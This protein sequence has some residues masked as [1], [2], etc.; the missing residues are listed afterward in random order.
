MVLHFC[1]FSLVQWS[2]AGQSGAASYEVFSSDMQL[3]EFIIMIILESTKCNRKL[4]G[5]VV[6]WSKAPQIIQF[7]YQDCSSEPIKVQDQLRLTLQPAHCNQ[8]TSAKNLLTL[9]W[10]LLIISLK[11]PILKL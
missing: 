9:V 6:D 7:T 1:N 3:L 4:S 8:L 2:I 10:I 11:H 5:L